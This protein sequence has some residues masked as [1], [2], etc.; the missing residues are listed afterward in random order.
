[1]CEFVEVNR[2]I[3]EINNELKMNQEGEGVTMESITRFHHQTIKL[4]AP[5]TPVHTSEKLSMC[6]F[7][8]GRT[9]SVLP[10]NASQ[11]F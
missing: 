3:L 6:V 1:M 9:V 5:S 8:K 10:Y 11:L 4:E 2:E 7:S